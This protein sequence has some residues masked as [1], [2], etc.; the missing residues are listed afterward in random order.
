MTAIEDAI[1]AVI[2]DHA[3]RILPFVGPCG[4]SW[5]ANLVGILPGLHGPTADL[6][7][8]AGLALLV[9][10][11]VHWYGIRIHGWRTYLRHYLEPNP[12]LL[13]FH[14]ISE[15]SRTV[16]LAVRSVREHVQSGDGGS[17]GS[18]GGG[19]SG[20]R[21]GVDAA[22]RRGPGASLYFRNA[23][24]DLYR[25]R[26]GVAGFE[27]R[28]GQRKSNMHD[29]TWFVVVSTGAAALAIAIGAMFPAQA[30][31][32]AIVQALEALARQ[33]EAERSITRT[34][35]HRTGDDRVSGDLRPGDRSDHPVPQSAARN[36]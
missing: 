20:A 24:A 22:H 7:T 10:L 29:M 35:V 12:I 26:T 8:T 3:G 9:F 23:S 4:S 17:A 21:S 28:K 33:P 1:A 27:A 36:T 31:G 19:V 2:P 34:L 6:S 30:M 16:A 32:R 11:S 5:C 18:A 15:I 13:P 25:Q 14:I